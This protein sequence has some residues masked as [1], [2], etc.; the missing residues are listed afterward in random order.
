MHDLHLVPHNL[1]HL[2]SHG[3]PEIGHSAGHISP[4]HRVNEGCGA[5]DDAQ[6]KVK[7]PGKQVD[8]GPHRVIE[9]ICKE[10][11]KGGDQVVELYAQAY[12]KVDHAQHRV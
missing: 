8:D 9:H 12:D 7:H 10:V 6:D 3:A 4:Q 2:C 1:L 11:R 5:L